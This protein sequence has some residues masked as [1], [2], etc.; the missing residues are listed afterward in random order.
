MNGESKSC[1][2]WQHCLCRKFLVFA[3][4]IQEQA[5]GLL[6]LLLLLQ[7]LLL[8]A[9]ATDTASTA[10]ALAAAPAAALAAEHGVEALTR[11]SSLEPQSLLPKYTDRRLPHNNSVSRLGFPEALRPFPSQCHS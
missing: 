1:A 9:A 6:L 11:S 7:Q 10:A 2:T 4:D 5:G 3:Y 8:F